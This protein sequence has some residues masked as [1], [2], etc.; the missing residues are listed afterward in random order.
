MPGGGPYEIYVYDLVNLGTPQRIAT[1]VS[2]GPVWVQISTKL[3]PPYG[4]IPVVIWEENLGDVYPQVYMATRPNCTAC[5]T[6][7][8]DND[9][10]VNATDQ[11]IMGL[12]WG[13]P[14]SCDLNG[15]NIVNFLDYQI[16]AGQWLQCNVQPAIYCWMGA[17][18][19][20]P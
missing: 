12:H 8:F 5:L 9:C 20:C 15:D 10:G 14:N 3:I 16:L 7:D 4:Y 2:S 6:A 17:T 19:P 18:F 11:A 13:L 1:G